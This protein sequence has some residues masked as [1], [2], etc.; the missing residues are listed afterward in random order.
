MVSKRESDNSSFQSDGQRPAFGAVLATTASTIMMAYSDPALA[1]E[2]PLA[3]NE[4]RDADALVREAGWNQIDADWRIFLDLGQV[5][6]VRNSNGRVVATAATLPHNGKFAW[7][8]MV[9]VSAD[10]QRQGLATRLLRR[11]IDDL[12]AGGLIP[13]LDATPTG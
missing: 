2:S 12:T 6:A 10:Y 7:I 9:L 3:V 13:V 4:F 11:C 5:Y 8:S 1:T